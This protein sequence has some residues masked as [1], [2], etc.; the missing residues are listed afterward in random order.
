M[1]FFKTIA[2]PTITHGNET[3]SGEK[4]GSTKHTDTRSKYPKQDKR[5]LQDR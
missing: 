1:R 4:A 2:V 5:M 3:L